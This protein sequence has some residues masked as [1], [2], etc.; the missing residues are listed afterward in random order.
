MCLTNKITPINS[1]V[2][3]HLCRLSDIFHYILILITLNAKF[4]RKS[5]A[6]AEDKEKKKTTKIN[7]HNHDK[8]CLFGDMNCNATC[9]LTPE[10]YKN[11]GSD[12]RQTNLIWFKVKMYYGLKSIKLNVLSPSVTQNMLDLNL[13]YH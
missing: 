11:F 2:L 5:L 7:R 9:K 3:F 10:K 12:F 13:H 8:I 6:L 1:Q 4:L